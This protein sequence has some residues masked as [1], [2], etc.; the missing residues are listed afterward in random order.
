MTTIAP[1]FLSILCVTRVEPHVAPFLDAMLT[2]AK[3]CDA[4]FVVA[5]DG[6]EAFERLL[7]IRPLA[8]DAEL[9]CVHSRG[10]VESVLD[11]ALESV[12]GDWVLRL[13]DDERV[14]GPLGEWLEERAFVRDPLWSFRRLNLWGDADHALETELLWPDPQTRLSVRELAGGRR[15]IHVASPHGLGSWAP[16]P[17]ALEHHKF[18]VKTLDERRAIATRYEAIEPGTGSGVFLPFSVPEDFYSEKVIAGKTKPVA[19]VVA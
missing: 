16:R 1:P 3:H 13:D 9:A 10:Y 4:E 17:C 6:F 14:N 5:A 2:L 18:L 7:A 19:E 12:R 11:Y 15:S 8:D